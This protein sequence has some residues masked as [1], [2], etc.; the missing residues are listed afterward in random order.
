MNPPYTQGGNLFHL[1]MKR[2]YPFFCI[3]FLLS[4]LVLMAAAQP[5]AARAQDVTPPTPTYDPLAEPFLPENPTEYELGRNLYWNFCMPC[6]G[7]KGQGLTDEWRAVWEP[8]HQDCW[9]YGC[10]AGERVQDSF[11]IPTI[12]PP[13]VSSRKLARFSSLQAL[14]EYLKAT[15]PPQHPGWLDDEQ[16]HAIALYVF[17]ENDRPLVES[18]PTATV[19]ATSTSTPIPEAAP[20][21]ESPQQPGAIIY[22]GLGI[23]LAV[24]VI[25]GIRKFR[26]PPKFV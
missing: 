1:T 6:H 9:G 18:I 25:W 24:V 5:Q 22:V 12:V 13:V 16:Y 10:H 4:A 11:A 26:K 23:I 17:S 3:A 14:S 7:D 19:R 21:E 8:D 2:C 15:H 20:V